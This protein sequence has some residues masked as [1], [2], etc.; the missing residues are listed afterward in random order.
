MV[1]VKRGFT[2]VE[3]LIIIVIIGILATI[4]VA[5][6]VN[7]QWRATDASVQATL[8]QVTKKLNAHHTVNNDYPPNLAGVQ[9]TPHYSIGMAFYTNAPQIRV[10]TGLSADQNAQLLLNTCNANMPIT[11]GSTQYNTVCVYNGNNAHIKGTVSSNVILHGPTIYQADIVLRCGAICDAT[12]SRIV[13]Q[14]LAQGGTFPVIV[15]KKNVTLP[16]TTA[17]SYGSSTKF[18]LEARSSTFDDIIYHTSSE[19]YSITKGLCPPSPELH[20]P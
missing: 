17:V 1:M 6:Y 15:P 9:F 20:Y 8:Q 16:G 14:F 10:Y 2:I 13:S 19:D 18:C 5:V 3:L 7:I 4:G 11:D 12:A